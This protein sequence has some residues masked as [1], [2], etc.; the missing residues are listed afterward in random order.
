[1]NRLEA[2]L[3]PVA[4]IEPDISR[5]ELVCSTLLR[6]SCRTLF[7]FAGQRTSGYLPKQAQH[8]AAEA[9]LVQLVKQL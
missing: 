9:D 2:S 3:Q 1:M 7:K 8:D 4:K 6:K 5:P